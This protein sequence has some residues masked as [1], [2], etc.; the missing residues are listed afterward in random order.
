[1]KT[2]FLFFITLIICSQS[3]STLFKAKESTMKYIIN[4][5]IELNQEAGTP[6]L[7]IQKLLNGI[8]GGSSGMQAYSR[9]AFGSIES[10]CTQGGTKL[11]NFIS[12]LRADLVADNAREFEARNKLKDIAK[13]A[14]GLNKELKE[15]LEGI[16]RL[17]QR[18]KKEVQEDT[19]YSIEAQEKLDVI[20]RL[21]DLISDE[22]VDGSQAGAFVQI[23]K[24]KKTINELKEKMENMEDQGPL[25][26]LISA[27]IS[28]TSEGNF[29]DQKILRSI[30]LLLNR[31][32]ENLQSF[33][34]KRDESQK[35]V[36]NLLR[37]QRNAK[38]KQYQEVRKLVASTDNDS[39]YQNGVINHA[40]GAASVLNGQIAK[41][42]KEFNQWQGLCNEEKKM[43]D[44]FLKSLTDF[45]GEIQRLRSV[46]AAL[47]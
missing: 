8:E 38:V 42:T 37:N 44:D 15:T 14:A 4:E 1:M 18:I 32:Q 31:I 12:Q 7:E 17:A 16:K 2:N 28:L 35:E 9:R 29:S 23:E 22:L 20:K 5:L 19:R 3:F 47:N 45:L 6:A 40:Q 39:R 41:K 10:T 30:L 46:V 33:Q 26:P 25:T 27:L 11:S 36:M 34:V 24:I 21:R 13:T 43:G